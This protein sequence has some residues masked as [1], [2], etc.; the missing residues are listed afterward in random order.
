LTGVIDEDSMLAGIFT[1]LK[2]HVVVDLRGIVHINSCGIRTWINVMTECTAGRK[3]EYVNCSPVIVRQFSMI[4]N[5]GV[6]GAVVSFMLP[7][8]CPRC[9]TEHDIGVETREYLRDHPG[10]D[11]P[12]ATCPSCAGALEFD[13]I[14][15][16]YFFF[17]SQNR[18]N[19]AD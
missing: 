17:L 14:E 4:S 3:V 11:A 10:F 12:A 15:S 13:D 8:Y 6:H 2:P 7:Y 1:G 16:K 19:T 5:F 18:L 9:D